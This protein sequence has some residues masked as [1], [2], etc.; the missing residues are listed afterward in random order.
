MSN[1]NPYA[2]Y[3]SDDSHQFSHHVESKQHPADIP[4]WH[5]MID[6]DEQKQYRQTLKKV[7]QIYQAH[8]TG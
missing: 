4:Q 3:Q 6:P 7:I 1:K 5:E 2:S 8:Q